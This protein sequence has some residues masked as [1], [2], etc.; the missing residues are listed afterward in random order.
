MILD[1]PKNN[2]IKINSN[3]DNLSSE[4][5]SKNSAFRPIIPKNTKSNCNSINNCLKKL[6]FFPFNF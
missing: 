3:K 2:L 1:K 5:I 4:N 6:C